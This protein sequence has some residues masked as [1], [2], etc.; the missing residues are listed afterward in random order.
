VRSRIALFF[1]LIL[2]ASTATAQPPVASLRGRVVDNDND[3]PLRRAI[4]SPARS[5]AGARAVLTDEDGRFTIDLPDPSSA[6]VVTKAGYA[7]T[8]SE[9]D[10]RTSKRAIDIRLQHGAAISGRIVE[11]G[12]PAVGAR[13]LA[14]RIDDASKRRRHIRPKPTTSA[15]TG[16]EVYPRGNTA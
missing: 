14:R 15:N 7:S 12:M 1:A 9:P 3:R 8:V 6:I 4:V 10:R 16:S 5:D 13:V 2:L 11:Q